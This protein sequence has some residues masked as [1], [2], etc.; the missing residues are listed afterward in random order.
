M[1]DNGENILVEFDYD[2]VSLIDPNKVIDQDGKVRDRLVKQENLVIYANLECSVVPRTK[3]AIG[4]PL[5]DNVRT[6]SVGKINF[7]NPGFKKFLNNN[8]TD[9]ITGKGAIKGEGVNQP[10]LNAVQNPKKSDDFYI[11]QSLYSN[12]TPGAVDNGL[13]GIKS[14]ETIID[15]NFYPQVTIQLE[16]V[17][18]RG[19]FEGGNSS[20]YAAFFQLPYPIFYL[21]LKGYYGKAVRMPLMLQTFNS[22][23]DNTSG[24]FKVTLKL[25]GYKYGVMSY[26]NWGHMLAVPHM[27]NSFVSTG[28]VSQGTPQSNGT[29]S[30]QSSD[31][32]KPIS[33]SRGYQKMKELYSEYKSK[34]LIDDD[35]PE[36]SL[37]QLKSKL[38]TFIK[39][40]LEKFTKENLGSLTELE[41]FQTLLTEFQKKVFFDTNSWYRTYMD[42]KFPLVLTDNTKVYT[43]KKD[44]DT[45]QKKSEA[46]TELDGIIKDFVKKLESNSVAGKDGS[47][48]VGGK[49]T[50][51]QVPVNVT[52]DKFKKTI[53]V[54]DV[55]FTKSF[56]EAYGKTTSGG[57]LVQEFTVAKST[58]IPT[59]QYFVFD[60]KGTFNDICNQAAKE[61]TTLRTE[62][63]KQITDNLAEQLAKK[64]SG[65]GFKPTIRNILAVFYAQGEAF[66]RLMDDVHNSAWEV[67]DDPYRRASVFGTTTAQSVDVKNAQQATEPIYPWPQI[68]LENQGDDSQEKFA[69][70]YPG[71]PKLS[72][73][74][75]AYIPELWPEVEFVEEYIKGFIERE[76]QEPD[77]GDSNNSE[78][79]PLRLSLNAV[80]FPISN[81]V[82]QNKEE[83]KYYYEIYERVMVNTFFSK[84]S[85]VDG[86][87]SS[88][89]L[90]ESENE[91]IN[92][93]KSLGVDNPF[94]I[95]KLK[96]Y[97]IDGNNYQTFLRHIS[98]QGE[99]ESW[100][101][102]IRGEFVTPYIKNKT[103]T[104]FQLFNKNILLS[105]SS[106]PNVSA[107]QQ[108]KIEDYVQVKTY[109]NQFDFTDM[110]PIT[111]LDWCKNY[112]ANGKGTN[113][114]NDIF[115]TNKILVYNTTH[116][117]ITSFKND[118]TTDTKRPI[119]NFNYTTD[120]FNQTIN[121]NLKQFYNNRKIE[122]QFITEGN[123]YYSGYTGYLTE[124]QTTSMM[125]TPY[126]VNAIQ[127]GVF[128]FRYNSK[129]LNPYKAAAY[130]FVNSLPVATLR[131]RF[132]TKNASED[133]DYIISTIKKFGA[134]HKL[135]YTWILKYGSIWHRYKT[136][137]REGKDILD[138]S[139]KD[140]NYLGNY[141]PVN[142]ATT[143]TYNLN[144]DGTQRN[145][146]LSQNFGTGSYT[147]YVN[148]GFYPKLIDDMN[149]FLQGLK[150]FS[151]STQLNGTCDIFN[152][153]MVVYTVN[154]NTLSPGYTL[155]GPN[156]DLN[157]TIVSQLSGT[158][159]GPGIYQ[160]TPIQNLTK[161]NGT[162]NISGTTLE[163]TFITG[164][165]LDVNAKIAG[166][167]IIP[168]TKIISKITG[169]SN[170]NLVYTIDT[171]QNFSGA[172]FF[173]ST[174]SDFFVTNSQTSGYG[175]AEVQSLI[176]DKK[177]VLS[178]NTNSKIIKT[179]GFDPNNPN[180]NLNLTPWSVLSKLTNEDKYY[181][182]PSF[183]NTKN[184][185]S[186]ECFKNGNLK[187]EITGNTAVF[188]GSARMFWGAPNYGYFDNNSLQIPDPDSYLK[189]I[190]NDK[191]IQENFSINGDKSKYTKISEIFT[192]FETKVLDVFEEEFLNYSR[193]IYD[194]KTL[195]AAEEGEETET[196]IAIKN[197]QYFMRLLMKIEKP[198]SIGTE[199]LID[200]VITKQ[201]LNFQSLF[202]SLMTYDTVFRF[203]N[204][205]MFDKRLF[206]TFSTKFIEEPITYQGYNQSMAGFLP[207]AG[208]TVTLAQ[209]KA[210]YPE[211]WKDLEYY[212][213]FSEIP[214][215]VYSD[216]GSYITDF[217]VD[218]NVQFSQK[219][220]KDFAPII[221]LY[222]THKLNKFKKFSSGQ[223]QNTPSVPPPSPVPPPNLPPPSPT[224][225]PNPYG[226]LV[227]V[228]TLTSGNTVSIYTLGPKLNSVLR[229]TSN[230]V[231]ADEG[232]TFT[233]DRTAM[234][235]AVI[236]NYYGSTSTNQND[237]QFVKTIQNILPSSQNVVVPQPTQNISP[238]QNSVVQQNNQNVNLGDFF[239]LMN[240]YLDTCELYLTNV[241]NDLMSG[242][243]N[244]LPDVAIVKQNPDQKAPL[245]G[246]QSRDELWDSF[247]SLNDT[248]ISG[249]DL[250]TKTLFED[251]LLFDRACRDVG[252]KVLVDIFKIKDLIETSLPNNKMENLIKTILQ[253]NNFSFF[254]L[255]AYSNFYNA[256]EV[257]KN[258]VPQP[259]GTTEFA[260]SMWGTFLNV[261]YRNTSP[262]Y[263]CYYRSVPSNHLAMNDNVDYKF[264]DDA[265]DL[266]RASDN[267]LLENQ[268]NKTNWDKS[269]KVCG[270]NVDFS[271]QN[272]QIFYQINLQQSVGK[273]TAE[274]LEMINQM[275]NASRNRGTGSQSVSLYNIYK[276][277]SYECTIDMM[278]N[279]LMQPMMYFNLRNVPMFSGPYMI[280][281]I[282]HSV[283]EGDFKTSITGTRQPFYDLPKVDNFIQALSFKIIDKLKDQLQKKETAELSSS[284][285]VISQINNV[286]STVS[287]KD[288]LT[289]NQNCSTKLNAT[290]QGFTN[291]AN[292][293][294]TTISAN[295]F[296]VLLRD[297]VRA[298]GYTAQT[299]K[300]VYLR[301]LLF[302]LI[303]MDSG[304]GNNLK[305]YENN[306]SSV[307]LDQTYGPA[308]I[309]FVDKNYYCVNRGTIKDIPMVKFTSTAKF[310]D[311]VISKA[312][313][314]LQTYMSKLD[315]ETVVKIYVTSWPTIKNGNVY[316]KLTEQDKKKLENAAKQA[317]DLFN[318]VNS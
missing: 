47:Y 9:E 55:D 160:I 217:F 40:I 45:A 122:E 181:V 145:I 93:L 38:D 6:I 174:P 246:D 13:L 304:S 177:L 240:E 168:G 299:E 43:F 101:K 4:A 92:A 237:P 198:T 54:N 307:S 72:S 70:K 74:T 216:N 225:L 269:N 233:S 106:Q 67:R 58:E 255:P 144:I 30:K 119:T 218:M 280:T 278:G 137:N 107:T 149:V 296:N 114:T 309:S 318:S 213:G 282:S 64:D 151:G 157:T 205:T 230:T 71:D 316:D 281:K 163:L 300:E 98:N 259:E 12:G 123:I 109:S 232:P 32:V 317:N 302:V 158:T 257:V 176:N 10:K 267:P 11:S 293:T 171:P 284:G 147:S 180:R 97:L 126:F 179:N 276:N 59:N 226:D 254:P 87:Q 238:V 2:N 139:W 249:I 5:N 263:L 208:G 285:N 185:V 264:R 182:F 301:Q 99:G 312:P 194:Y 56:N 223:A 265:F 83:V 127:N 251:I 228:A 7:L 172:T 277:R 42:F 295:E 84:L 73:I 89:Y 36:Y 289:T 124:N 275:A 214:E 108:N 132:K 148:T 272:Q 95:K 261:D 211:T 21:T 221:K 298:N 231:L 253:E 52:I 156:V 88:V 78:Q 248:W 166:P 247:K 75:K 224:P 130:L 258:P 169:S 113:G 210:A 165:T 311:F 128:N 315:L 44:Y 142:S 29:V 202:N 85:R 82:F 271:N 57:T 25:Y 117:S 268:L 94:L 134:V 39:D 290:Y 63:E 250:K 173:V 110:Y 37:F 153:T 260:S 266:R 49:Q 206:Y 131:E 305:A 90:V 80:D 161:I 162:C 14:I 138:G 152:D 236:I 197:F 245:V 256:Q 204:P 192:T 200:E 23:F 190:F 294:L 68:I 125:N 111:N 243:R 286:V 77:L 65:I 242:I 239:N 186:D 175:Q 69:L 191:K 41:N 143:K 33:V 16:D 167:N 34:G 118:D 193:S 61:L 273:P 26:I 292:P 189:Q 235:N 303:F 120:I 27:Y 17:K 105:P 20:P 135:P 196:E 209:S 112:L 129:D 274:S 262:K 31:N 140:F 136:W 313:S 244:E 66:L 121:S 22:T 227:E 28:Q 103:N 62:I 279:A 116:K 79:Q 100:Q 19:L 207:T 219:N 159:G 141:D 188:N 91:K 104:P 1:V 187:L 164:G 178:T 195:I 51:S 46:I 53:T 297:K 314:I 150:L 199:G 184:Q 270:F 76:A 15:T 291:V 212:V 146:V 308:F 60:G 220:V 215:L 287:E 201:N 222:A 50:K 310:L 8:W 170:P 288:V 81:E 154:D 115:N 24:N 48:T 18:G 203:G 3:L 306:F 96:Q 35:F 86:Y 229:D 252:Q 102:F 155:S 133:L 283:S 183:G 241:V 234:R